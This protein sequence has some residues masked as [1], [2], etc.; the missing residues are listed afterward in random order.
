MGGFVH[1]PRW[2]AGTSGMGLAVCVLKKEKK[3]KNSVVRI[4]QQQPSPERLLILY[5][6]YISE[7]YETANDLHYQKNCR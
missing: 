4:S 2:D 1:I 6:L 7:L 5:T 3:K